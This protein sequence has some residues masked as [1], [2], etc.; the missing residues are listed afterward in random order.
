MSAPVKC[1]LAD[2]ISLA[3]ENNEMVLPSMP[4]WAIKVQRML[5]DIN[6][7]ASQIVTAVSSDPGFAA[8]L[9]KTA[10][11][12]I[13]AGKPRVENVGA[14]VS[15]LGFKMLRN[16]VVAV[17]MSKLVTIEKP[18]IR[19]RLGEYW[20]HSREVAAISYILAQSQK[21]LNPDQAMLAGLTHD[22]G[23]LPLFM[24]LEKHPYTIDETVLE[25]VI[26]RCGGPIGEK[27]L[28][29]WEFPPELIE[30]PVAHENLQREVAT[31]MCSYADIVTVANLLNRA[32]AN[33]VKWEDIAA[34]DRLGI[35]PALYRE[36]FERFDKDLRATRE[37]LFQG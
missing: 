19:K 30:V 37:M 22:I 13:Y 11:S 28:Q 18:V 26:I 4:A 10:N 25:T 21:H 35:N 15:R 9:I 34:V 36:F 23:V 7:S 1:P 3:I 6:A 29:F 33:M 8:Q 14:A 32:S 31:G 5:D 20:E 27:L 17:A 12:A 24:H 2:E 16:L